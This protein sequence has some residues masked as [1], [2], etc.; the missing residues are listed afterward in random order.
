MLKLSTLLV[1]SASALAA[2]QAP[3]VR[4][5]NA[6]DASSKQ[7]LG[8]VA[9][10]RQLPTGR[11][12][13]NDVGKRQL[14]LFDPTLSNASIVADSVAGGAN[15]YGP[16]AGGIISYIGD[17]TLFIDPRDLSMFVLDPNGAIARVAA[18]PRSQDAGTL[19]SNMLG[20][21]ALDSKGR[22]VYRGGLGRIMKPA[23]PGGGL[24]VPDFPDSSAIVRIDLASR[25]LDTA[26][27]YKIPK[28]KM[29]IVQSDKGM[30][31]TSEINPMQIVDDW[32]VI[33]DGSIAIVRGQDYH[34][35]WVNADGSTTTSSKLSFDWQRLSDEDKVAVIDSAKASS[36]R[37]AASRATGLA[38]GMAAA[39]GGGGAAGDGMV[40][41][42]FRSG[43]DAGGGRGAVGG[44]PT[45]SPMTFVSPSELPDYRPVFTQGATRADLDGNLWIRTSATRNGAIAGPIYDVVNRKGEVTDRIQVPSGRTIVGFAKGGIVYMMARD[46]KGAWLERTHR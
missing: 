13:V 33:A 6:A 30:T 12:L 37:A 17:S 19:G 43:G 25:K 23:G 35:D 36:E 10:V 20:S 1:A 16:S 11:L 4:L 44:G 45:A 32:A 21:P 40:V 3:A 31:M 22:I 29:N 9:A 8:N 42:S 26:A 41:M 18:V 34:I 24:P 2:Q 5:I 46:D 7:V 38:A 14:M 28:V 27:F 15:S 39:G